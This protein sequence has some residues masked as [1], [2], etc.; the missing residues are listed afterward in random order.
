M[1]RVSVLMPVKNTA[2]YLREAIAS[3]QAQTV[4][5]FEIVVLDDGSRDESPHVIRTLAEREPRMRAIYRQGGGLIAARNELLEA[6]RGEFVAWL[7]SDDRMTTDRLAVQLAAFER[8]RRLVLV[9]GGATLTD[10]TGMPI[11]THCFAAE[12]ED[13]VAAMRQEIAFYFPAVTMRR[14][15]AMEL[16]G[17]REPFTIAEDFDLCLRMSEAGRVANV[18]QV[19]LFYRQHLASTANSGRPKTFAYSKLARELAEERRVLGQD[20]LQRGEPVT[21]QFGDLPSP[22]ENA[23]ETHKRWA[24]WALGSG[25]LKT[26]RKYALRVLRE[27]PW[28]LGSWRLA[29]CALRGH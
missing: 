15:V 25:Y 2:A 3:V 14:K 18:Q 5:D 21:V 10:P 11:R 22:A 7:D 16:G 4:Q 23:R 20:R 9:G 19:V 17:F 27:D 12:H 1:P 29:A 28:D 26:A 8:D 6:A 13:L 24:W